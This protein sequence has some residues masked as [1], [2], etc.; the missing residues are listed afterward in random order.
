MSTVA[1]PRTR[2]AAPDENY[3]LVFAS[4]EEA[5]LAPVKRAGEELV[6][7]RVYKIINS[8][9]EPIT[10]PGNFEKYTRARNAEQALN[11]VLVLAGLTADIANP[12]H[13]GRMRKI[14]LMIVRLIVANYDMGSPDAMLDELYEEVGEHYKTILAEFIAKL[15]KP[16]DA[17]NKL[18]RDSI[19]ENNKS[20]LA[21]ISAIHGKK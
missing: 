5:N 16:N 7:F 15:Q 20:V 6:D 1:E 2:K 11:N 18:E 8:T 14:D 13:R 9:G 4:E 3:K 12:A 17:S 10:L 21:E 19:K